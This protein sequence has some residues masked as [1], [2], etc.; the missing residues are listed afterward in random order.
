MSEEIFIE[1]SYNRK[2]RAFKL[3]RK[4][5]KKQTGGDLCVVVEK[6]LSAMPKIINELAGDRKW[7]KVST[8][9]NRMISYAKFSE[10][11]KRRK[12]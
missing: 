10:I 3:A 7:M 6:T 9:I 2:V 1:G 12:K 5:Y 4:I 8:E 11:C